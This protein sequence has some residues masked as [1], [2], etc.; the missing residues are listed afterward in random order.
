MLVCVCMCGVGACVM[1]A[2]LIV[3]LYVRDSC[4]YVSSFGCVCD[5]VC[6]EFVCVCSHSK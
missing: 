6:F 1:M 4:V 3:G 2:V 5:G